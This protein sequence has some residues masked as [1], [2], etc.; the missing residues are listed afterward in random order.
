MRLLKVLKSIPILLLSHTPGTVLF[1]ANANF[2]GRL[3][4]CPWLRF[5]DPGVNEELEKESQVK[6]I[7][8][9]RTAELGSG[10]GR[11][12]PPGRRKESA[13]D[14]SPVQSVAPLLPPTRP[15][16]PPPPTSTP[17]SSILLP[18][19]A[20]PPVRVYGQ[21]SPFRRTYVTAVQVAAPIGLCWARADSSVL[22][23]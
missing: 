15:P 22:S 13:F 11:Q 8:T 3:L 17:P 10:T 4:L 21:S 18:P 7:P 9:S 5:F 16:T 12:A 6:D 2:S 20:P 23:V 1:S 19:P 14:G